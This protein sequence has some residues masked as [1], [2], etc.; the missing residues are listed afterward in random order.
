MTVEALGVVLGTITTIL[1]PTGFIFRFFTW[2]GFAEFFNIFFS[3]HNTYISFVLSRAEVF[4]LW[5]EFSQCNKK[6]E[7]S[8]M[9]TK[10]DN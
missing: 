5:A 6:S 2:F 9:N 7:N 8:A 3:I 10:K 4:R 1:V